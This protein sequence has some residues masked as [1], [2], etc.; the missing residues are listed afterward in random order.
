VEK[1]PH[2]PSDRLV[3]V[4]Q[5]QGC[6]APVLPFD[7]TWPFRRAGSAA[8]D[9]SALGRATRPSTLPEPCRSRYRIALM[10]RMST[11][12]ISLGVRPSS[13][14]LTAMK[15]GV[16][17]DAFFRQHH[18]DDVHAA[19]VRRLVFVHVQLQQH[20]LADVSLGGFSIQGDGLMHGCSPLP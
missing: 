17:P 6:A 11:K 13:T 5:G 2:A 15:Y 1:L 10:V 20:G 3:M 8:P 18:A 4:V 19:P 12:G 14:K 7:G 16:I 9:L